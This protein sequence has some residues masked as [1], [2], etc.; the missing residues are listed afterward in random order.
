M[1]S[2]DREVGWERVPGE[3]EMESA[4]GSPYALVATPPSFS[5]DAVLALHTVSTV[6]VGLIPLL[7]IR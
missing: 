1:G 6:S 5:W 7:L 4:L 3:K 2:S